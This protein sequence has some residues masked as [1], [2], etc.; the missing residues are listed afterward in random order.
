MVF[1]W[2][3]GLIIKYLFRNL[4]PVQKD[5]DIRIKSYRASQWLPQFQHHKVERWLVCV[6][7]HGR[8]SQSGLTEDIKMG[9]CV[10]QCDFPHQW[11]LCLYT[12]TGWSV[13][14]CVCCG[15]AFLCGSTL[16]EVSLLQAGSVATWPQ[17]F[18]SYV[19]PHQTNL[20]TEILHAIY[21]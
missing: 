16:V 6:D 8:I 18:I 13:I 4:L 12:V 17:M 9:S 14:S 7:G 20:I 19:K 21:E 10:F 2:L 1:G 5:K 15:M 3:L 11:T